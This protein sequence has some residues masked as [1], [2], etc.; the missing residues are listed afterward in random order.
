MN[1][2]LI[3]N[4]GLGNIYF[5]K[6]KPMVSLSGDDRLLESMQEFRIYGREDH[7]L[8]VKM[9]TSLERREKHPEKRN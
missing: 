6:I 1:I 7:I 9:T 8:G 2:I 3:C 4:L 5:V